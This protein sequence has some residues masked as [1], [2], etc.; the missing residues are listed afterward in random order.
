MSTSMTC[1]SSMHAW[2]ATV[3]EYHYVGLHCYIQLL[4]GYPASLETL[5]PGLSPP[6]S[7][8]PLSPLSYSSLPSTLPPSD[9]PASLRI[10]AFPRYFV[11]LDATP[12]PPVGWGGVGVTCFGYF[13]GRIFFFIDFLGSSWNFPHFWNVDPP[14]PPRTLDPRGGVGKNLFYWFSGH[15]WVSPQPFYIQPADSSSMTLFV[16]KWRAQFKQTEWSH[17]WRVT[18]PPRARVAARGKRLSKPSLNFYCRAKSYVL[19]GRQTSRAHRC[20]HA[21]RGITHVSVVYELRSTWLLFINNEE[22]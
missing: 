3:R 11:N 14:T 1:S 15:S 20:W 17:R 10:T 19:I 9:Y 4:A 12:P 21:R 22:V 16:P 5:S 18:R 13:V 2:V 7:L 8:V 6:P